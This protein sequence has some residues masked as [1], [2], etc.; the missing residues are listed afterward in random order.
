MKCPRIMAG[1]N[2]TLTFF[3][4][5]SV[6]FFSASHFLK[7]EMVNDFSCHEQEIQHFPINLI[8][9]WFYGNI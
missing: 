8:N 5:S 7:L 2:V 3:A 1:K 6:L 4:S 9:C